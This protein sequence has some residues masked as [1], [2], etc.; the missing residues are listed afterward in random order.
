MVGAPARRLQH[1][2]SRAVIADLQHAVLAVHAVD[3]AAQDQPRRRRVGR[4][5]QHRV[6]ADQHVAVRAQGDGTLAVRDDDRSRLRCPV[7][8]ADDAV[9]RGRGRRAEIVVALD[10]NLS[11]ARHEVKAPLVGVASVEEIVPRVRFH[12]HAAVRIAAALHRVGQE[13]HLSGLRLAHMHS[14]RPD[15]DLTVGKRHMILVSRQRMLHRTAVNVERGIFRPNR[16]EVRNR[17]RAAGENSHHRRVCSG[18]SSFRRLV[19]ADD[20]RT[21][22]CDRHLA[23]DV[24]S[25]VGRDRVVDRQQ[26]RMHRKRRDGDRPA[27]QRV[28]RA[29][30]MFVR[31]GCHASCG[32]FKVCGDASPSRLHLRVR[33]VGPRH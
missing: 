21:A 8:L 15:L 17:Q 33:A 12:P 31:A 23:L 26:A 20:E 2:G 9:R 6:V 7:A 13:R 29:L 30:A 5:P 4:K 14:V 24:E 32:D 28:G 22:V 10:A 25:A 27:V 18:G 16:C 1:D 3:R 11:A 19:F